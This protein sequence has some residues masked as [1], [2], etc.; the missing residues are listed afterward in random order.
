MHISGSHPHI[1]LGPQGSNRAK[2]GFRYDN[3]YLGSTS[4]GGE[5]ILKNNISSTDAPDASGDEIARFGDTIVFNEGSRDQDFRVES[6][7]NANMLF[8]DA[9]TNRV[10]IG[11]DA[12]TTPLSVH[13]DGV[14][15]KIDGA[16]ANTSRT[17]LFRSVGTGEGIVQTDG[18]MHLLQE[19]A[20]RYMRFSTANTE[21]MRI[22]GSGAVI[23][24]SAVASTNVELNL[25]GVASKA[26][27]IQFQESGTN[28]WLLGQG[29]AS[30]NECI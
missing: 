19:D 9:S 26:Q 4:G 29:A 21:R 15:L 16:A 18:N 11:T 8:V 6:D 20:S 25:N 12:P 5:V 1:D 30:E 28:R 23:V 24:G 10:G 22:E 3:L 17:L 7:S 2:L 27:R 13:G 14:V